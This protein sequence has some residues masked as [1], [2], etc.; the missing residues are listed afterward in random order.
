MNIFIE[1]NLPNSY[2]SLANL[3]PVYGND[4]LSMSNKETHDLFLEKIIEFKNSI[5]ENLEFT[6]NVYKGRGYYSEIQLMKEGNELYFITITSSTKAKTKA[7]I[8]LLPEHP[9]NNNV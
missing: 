5:V 9:G 8:L 2:V 4:V 1:A 6:Q 7:K 3:F